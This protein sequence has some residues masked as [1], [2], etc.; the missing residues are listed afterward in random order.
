LFF[1]YFYHFFLYNQR[2]H[3][4][5]RCRPEGLQAILNGIEFVRAKAGG[6][7]AEIGTYLVELRGPDAVDGPELFL[8]GQ[9]ALLVG[10]I[11]AP[12]IAGC[13]RPL[14]REYQNIPV[15]ILHSHLLRRIL[16]GFV[17][18]LEEEPLEFTVIV[19][20]F[21][22]L[23]IHWSWFIRI[24]YVATTRN[25]KPWVI[26]RILKGLL[27]VVRNGLLGQPWT[28]ICLPD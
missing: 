8:L 5:Q 12:M 26:V 17:V 7:V 25:M 11:L 21:L 19:S 23:L 14:L 1:V 6:I 27:F 28:W 20:I 4:H 16:Q 13:H 9:S 15:V 22:W 3:H 24:R 2:Y 10:I 18:V